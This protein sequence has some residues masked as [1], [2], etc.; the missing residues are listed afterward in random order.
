MPYR[1][2][3]STGV[4]PALKG[5]SD[6]LGNDRLVYDKFRVIPNVVDAHNNVRGGEEPDQRRKAGSVGADVLDV[7]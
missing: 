3:L 1:T 5:V 4:P 7:V 6:N 2:W